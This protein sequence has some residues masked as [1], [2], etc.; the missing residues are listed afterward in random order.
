[1]QKIQLATILRIAAVAHDGQFD[2]GG[3][4]YIL[5]PIAVMNLLDDDVKENELYQVTAI[6]HDLL[7]DTD[8][9]IHQLLEAGIDKAAVEAIVILTKMPGQSYEEYKS[10]VKA[11]PITRKVKKADLRHNSDFTRL[12]GVREKDKQRTAKYMDFFY[13]LSQEV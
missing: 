3:H 12:K 13:E 11:N 5:H 2:K 10:K 8:I 9:T 1:M 7:E 6:G 4:P